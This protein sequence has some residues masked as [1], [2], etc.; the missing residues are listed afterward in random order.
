MSN[1]NE[2]HYMSVLETDT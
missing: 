2:S 1:A